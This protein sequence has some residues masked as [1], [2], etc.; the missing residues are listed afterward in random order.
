MSDSG[1]VVHIDLASNRPSANRSRSGSDVR[2]LKS[3]EDI[4]DDSE[5]Y[6]EDVVNRSKSKK[7][8]K[9]RFGGFI[10]DE[11]EVDDDIDEDGE[12]YEVDSTNGKIGIV[13]EVD[14]LGPTAREI[15]IHQRTNVW[16]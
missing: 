7:K 5:Q 8:K 16:E 15:E 11:A 6:E 14:E 13:N 9:E 12:D 4:S 10:L 3:Q 2:S 1:S